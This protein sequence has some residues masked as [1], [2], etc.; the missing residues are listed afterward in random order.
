MNDGGRADTVFGLLDAA[1]RLPPADREAWIRSAAVDDG[2]R[3]EALAM[4]AVVSAEQ[5]APGSRDDGPAPTLMDAQLGDFRVI[6][7]IGSG[8]GGVVYEA[9]QR[10]PRRRVALKV[11]RA[12]GSA[13]G[14]R[15]AAEAQSLA[16]FRHPGIAS[17]IA[18]GT[19]PVPGGAV[20]AWIAMELIEGARTVVDHCAGTRDRR[21][22]ARPLI[23]MADAI[24]AAHRAGILHRDI[25]PAN[26]LVGADGVARVVDFGVASAA[27]V[28]AEPAGTPRWMAPE[29]AAGGPASTRSDVWSLG[30]VLA[31][32]CDAARLAE[33]DP[34]RAA[35]GMATSADPSRRY[36]DASELADDLRR[37]LADEPARC[38]RAGALS[39]LR[40]AVRRRPRSAA[41]AGMAIVTVL[42]IGSVF[43][44]RSALNASMLLD[45]H[46]TLALHGDI[47]HMIDQLPEGERPAAAQRADSR[48]REDLRDPEHGPGSVLNAITALVRLSR[49]NSA[50]RLAADGRAA[51]R[52]AGAPEDSLRWI[53]VM[54]DACRASEPGAPPE[55]LAALADSAASIASRSP[56]DDLML[57][58]Y[59]EAIAVQSGDRRFREL[60]TALDAEFNPDPGL[61]ATTT[62]LALI[63]MEDARAARSDPER[64]ASIGRGIERWT[65]WP[66]REF[67]S[68]IYMN[69]LIES[70]RAAAARGDRGRF[71]DAVPLA[72]LAADRCARLDATVVTEIWIAIGLGELREDVLALRALDAVAER[73]D[74]GTLDPDRVVAWLPHRVSLALRAP[75]AAGE[76]DATLE[77][78]RRRPILE[79]ADPELAALLRAVRAGS[80]EA[81]AMLERWGAVP[82]GSPSGWRARVAAETA[83]RLGPMAGGN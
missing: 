27:G 80:P 8:A 45:L 82:R 43:A 35:A 67:N 55:A 18:A 1:L 83:A 13:A 51:L 76:I 68:I 20:A 49:S 74:L 32:C 5:S 26:L 11:L 75:D 56:A 53:V 59:I 34:I 23:A 28:A 72:R 36:A 39:R 37:V 21:D 14:E 19:A 4:L 71:D 6:R 31:E 57:G 69:R 40:S 24:G 2:V 9:E 41:A 73:A 42:A 16:M 25:K 64:L 61:S 15:A 47:A 60:A 44:Y 46:R 30:R 22:V 77:L 48:G 81:P 54:D 58:C 12:T 78:L 66:M 29:C 63:A 70:M 38:V 10:L 33:S 65:A 62:M 79:T 17:V 52:E 7:P 50:C 3:D